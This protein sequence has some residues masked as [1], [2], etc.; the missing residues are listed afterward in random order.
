MMINL[1]FMYIHPSIPSLIGEIQKHFDGF[2]LEPQ[3]AQHTR[4]NALSG[5]QKVKVSYEDDACVIRMLI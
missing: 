1:P 4:M 2:G 5:G 3:F